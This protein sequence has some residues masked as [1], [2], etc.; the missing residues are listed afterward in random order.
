MH[1]YTVVVREAL[2]QI[3]RDE[4][5]THVFVQAGVGGLSAAVCAYLWDA[6]GE[7]RPVFTVV[8][9]AGAACLFASA[10]AGRPTHVREI[11]TI[12]AGLECGEVSQLAWKI[13]DRGADYF[14]TVPDDVVPGCMQI[15]ADGPFGDPP[16]IAGESAVAGLAAFFCVAQQADTRAEFGLDE[17]SRVLVIGSE[18]DTDTERYRLISGRDPDVIRRST[19]LGQRNS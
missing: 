5:P 15:L 1:G 16:I 14:A 3:R 11:H 10:V 2:D 13:L 18:G 19:G 17:N 7:D 9:P 6:L 8:E 4:L 12:M